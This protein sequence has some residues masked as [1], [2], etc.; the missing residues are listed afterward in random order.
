MSGDQGENDPVEVVRARRIELVDDHGRVRAVVGELA[1][2][3]AG[4]EGSF[5]FGVFD[6][7]AR[8]RAW[9]ALEPSGPLLVFDQ[10]GNIALQLGVNDPEPDGLHPGAHLF[11][12]SADGEPRIGWRIEGSAA[13]P[14]SD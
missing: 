12:A 7:G 13:Q 1:H 3:E 6:T 9:F 11:L 4:G 5:G 8:L 10:E 14:I 2:D